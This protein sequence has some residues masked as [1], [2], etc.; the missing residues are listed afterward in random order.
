MYKTKANVGGKEKVI[1]AINHTAEQKDK[2]LNV[3]VQ[4]NI[5][6]IDQSGSMHGQISNLIDQVEKSF[7]YMDSND[8]VSVIGFSAYDECRTYIK[9][10]KKDDS[11]K[12]FLNTMRRTFST[13]CFSVPFQ[14]AEEIVDDLESICPNFAIT[15]FTDGNPVVPWGDVEEEN[16]VMKVLDTLGKKVIAVNTIGYGYYYNQEFMLSI[17]NRSEFG[18][19]THSRD[20]KDYQKIFS[21]NYERVAELSTGSIDLKAPG[22]EIV[23]LTSKNTKLSNDS[24]VLRMM[25]KAK[26]QMFL[27]GDG[28][29]T[30]EL[31]GVQYDTR[32]LKADKVRSD[33]LRNMYY[34]Y[35]YNAYYN[36]NR[37]LALDVL[38]K[39]VGDKALVDQQL[40]AFT[41]D[42]V[43]KYAQKLQTTVFD[44]KRRHTQ[45]TCEDDYLPR[46][47][48][49]CV[50]DVLQHLSTGANNYYIPLPY[51]EYSRVG[52]T[53]VDTHSILKNE[54]SEAPSPFGDLVFHKTRL[55]I[56]VRHIIKK[57][58]QLNPRAASRVGLPE[59]I[60]VDLVRHQTIVK[61]GNLNVSRIQ[62]LVD[63]DTLGK[64]QSMGIA[65]DLK[66]TPN[67]D[68]LQRVN[69]PLEDLPIVNRSYI[70]KST[71]FVLDTVANQLRFEARQKVLRYFLR[72]VR[73]NTGFKEGAFKNY[74]TEQIEVLK[75]HGIDYKLNYTGVKNETQDVTDVYETRSLEFQ[76]KGATSLPKIDDVLAKMENNGKMNDIT[77]YMANYVN[78]LRSEAK[79]AGVDLDSSSAGDFLKQKLSAL[80]S[81]IVGEKML[82]NT[83]KIA[84]I[85]TG[86]W[87]EGTTVDGRGNFVYE[88]N[89]QTLVIKTGREQVQV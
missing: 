4:H 3:P 44:N 47:D 74:T 37:Q 36:G 24:L 84:K 49:P 10:A 22:V 50:M 61:D 89:G 64:L 71:D 79:N 86:D 1:V 9:G 56:S 65:L 60:D 66:G 88:N 46:A 13:T 7:Q 82:L 80:K 77:K 81:V 53:I 12:E 38:V 19:F 83:V 45:G 16:R 78:E 75:D 6:L 28:D 11:I 27:L 41:Y 15:L 18:T 52:K 87:F 5:I 42:E 72:D 35:A 39:D 43:A 70:T 85:V 55:N 62:A 17:S 76:I 23:Y 30:F 59:E 51:D 34:A 26:N 54:R 48:A 21:H 2:T 14:T 69:I 63:T 31:D 20:I 57:T 29:F 8:Y 58:A 73:E 25:G 67:A 68:G 40:Q 32:T 33:T